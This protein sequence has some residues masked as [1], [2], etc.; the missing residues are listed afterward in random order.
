MIRIPAGDF[1]YGDEKETNYLPE[2]WIDK[3]PVTIAEYARFVQETGQESA[4]GAYVQGKK[5][6]LRLAGQLYPN[7]PVIDV[8]WPDA[9]AYAAWA[10]KRLPSEEEW[11]KAARGTDG[12]T[13]LWG[14]DKLDKTVCNFGENE[15]GITPVG[16]YSP[17]GD[18]PYDCVDM[19]GNVWEWCQGW[20]DKNE[21]LRV[22]RGGGW[23]SDGHNL[24]V[25]YRL[26]YLPA[27]SNL[28]VGVRCVRSP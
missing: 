3:I 24:R 11:E 16:Q 26:R 8:S 19:A 22:V 12:R 27:G 1:L 9:R 18:S 17:Q 25:A 28:I 10:G 21:I 15:K 2:Y 5:V 6:D 20:Y 23:G 13:Y 7:H 14:E 4:A